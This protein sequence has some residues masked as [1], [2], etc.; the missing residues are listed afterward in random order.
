MTGDWLF[1]VVLNLMNILP[2][3]GAALALRGRW[4]RRFFRS[5]G[6]N[7]KLS[8]HVNIYNPGRVVCGNSVYIGYGVYFGG[9]DI[10]LEDE[11]IIGPYCCIAAGNHTLKNGS[12]RFGPY[13]FGSI[14]IGRGTWLGAHV[15][16]TSNVRIGKGCLVAAN[17]V[18][19][20]DVPDFS[21]VGGVPAHVLT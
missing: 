3:K 10:V 19:T 17:S 9:G 11:V 16:V 2:G 21:V 1:P 15:T 18:V 12:Y 5:C 8:A 7:L 6:E 14:V 13:E 4:A 20:A